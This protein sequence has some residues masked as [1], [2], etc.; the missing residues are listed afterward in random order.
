MKQALRK[1]WPSLLLGVA[2]S[3]IALAYLLRRDLSGVKEELLHAHYWAVIPC[4]GLSLIGLWLRS[5]RWRVLLS[6]R[7]T[8]NH[9][10]HILNVS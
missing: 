6:G 7:I 4:V 10:F 9:S 2:V 8:P 1:R 3:G 5:L